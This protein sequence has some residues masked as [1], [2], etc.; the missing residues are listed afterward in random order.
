MINFKG[1]MKDGVGEEDG[2]NQC[3]LEVFQHVVDL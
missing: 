1:E 3:D 2:K